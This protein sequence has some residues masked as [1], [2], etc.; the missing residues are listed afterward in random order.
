MLLQAGFL[1]N[2]NKSIEIPSQEIEFLGFKLNSLQMV[3]SLPPRKIDNIHDLC[4]DMLAKTSIQIRVLAKFIGIL[5]SSLPG[6]KYG[7][8]YYRFLERD[9][10]FAL[11]VS[12][13]NYDD[14]M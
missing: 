13:G 1:I 14:P 4:A 11:R 12:K 6:V 5:V 3:I 2:Q 10:N 8:L 7:E 9:R